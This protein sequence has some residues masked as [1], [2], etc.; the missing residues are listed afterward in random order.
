MILR[1]IK[2]FILRLLLLFLC[3]TL[4]APGLSASQGMESEAGYAFVDLVVNVKHE[5]ADTS[6]MQTVRLHYRVNRTAIERDYMDNAQA[7]EMLDRIF[8]TNPTENIAYI[9]I[10]GSASPEGSP[11]NNARLA[12]QRAESLKRYILTNYPGLHDDQIVTIPLGEDWGGLESMIENDANVPYRD[13]LLRILRSGISREEQKRQMAVLGNGQPYK[14]L[15]EY[16]L[17]HLRG[18]VS[19]TIYFRERPTPVADTVKIV[20]VDTVYREIYIPTETIVYVQQE[21]VPPLAR[22]KKP[23]FIAVKT[24]LLY[25]AALLP[26]LSIEIPF[27]QN[28]KWSAALEG[29]WSWWDTGASKYNYH[30]IQMAGVE[31]RRWFGNRSG[32]PLNGWYVGLYGYGGD[33]D[34]RLFADKNSDIG[35]QSL[36]S[37]SGGLTFGYAMPVGRR[38]NLEFGFGVGYLGGIYKKYNVSDCRDGVFPLLSTHRRNYF[39][40]TKATVSLVWQ[41]G[42]GV[43]VNDRKGVARW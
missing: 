41:I 27:G 6:A 40:L 7:L 43:N 31:V 35:Q 30:R 9:V 17:P 16:I 39:G 22:A 18:G 34:I 29:N 14:Y 42:S 2:P 12:E 38:F 11:Q 23:F 3:G 37:Y 26:N 24:N 20:R 8:S 36:W 28:Y 13:E 32:N 4:T 1:K 5:P 19:G 33:Y 21:V 15:Q 25:D 10:T